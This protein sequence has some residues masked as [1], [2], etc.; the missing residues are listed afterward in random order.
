MYVSNMFVEVTKVWTSNS[1]ESSTTPGTSTLLDNAKLRVRA[2]FRRKIPINCDALEA[3][4]GHLLH[5][6]CVKI[7]KNNYNTWYGIFALEH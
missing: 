4:N 2:L 5:S 1:P 6:C 7:P 3:C